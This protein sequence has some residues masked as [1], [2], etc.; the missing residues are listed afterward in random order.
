MNINKLQCKIK[1]EKK[2]DLNKDGCIVFED[3]F[4]K[5]LIQKLSFK[6]NTLI[7]DK[8]NIQ[9]PQNVFDAINKKK[10]WQDVERLDLNKLRIDE[11]NKYT[12]IITLKDPLIK[13]PELLEIGLNKQI[14]E[15]ITK[16]LGVEPYLSFV[17]IRKSLINDLPG[18]DSQEWNVD[19]NGKSIIKAFLIISD[20]NEY[21]G[22]TEYIKGSHN[23]RLNE[24]TEKRFTSEEVSKIFPN[25]D[26]LK[27]VG[28]P[29][30][31]YLANTVGFHRAG[32]PKR[33][34][35]L[36]A[37]FNYVTQEEYKGLYKENEVT[38]I[39]IS[40][41]DYQSLSTANKKICSLMEII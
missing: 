36:I 31:I 23:N 2:Y 19:G 13:I 10:K 39:R 18:Y 6:F 28:K 1:F 11:I 4:D 40:K 16:C 17:K 33:N 37:I 15:E 24:D 12:N 34:E 41:K 26:I 20:V 7:D 27:L 22:P 3:I 8:K 5:N 9:T 29:G 32:V 25:A 38:K 30:T 21:S 14:I 35:R